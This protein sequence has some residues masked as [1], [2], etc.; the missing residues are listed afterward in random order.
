MLGYNLSGQL[1]NANTST[2]MVPMQVRDNTGGPG[3]T[4][5]TEITAS[6]AHSCGIRGDGSAW[7]W[8]SANLGRRGD[9][10]TTT[11]VNV[12]SRVGTI[13]TNTLWSDWA[14]I[15]SYGSHTCGV[16]ADGTG[17]CWGYGQFGKLGTGSEIDS[18]TPVRVGTLATSTL[19]SDWRTIEGGYGHT[20][21]VRTDGSAWCW[22][23]GNGGVLGGSS[24]TTSVPVRI[25]TDT[26]GVG[27]SDWTHLTVQRA[28]GCGTR[29]D[30]S[31]WCWG[32]N[33][34]G[35]LGDNSTTSRP[36]PVR[37]A[38]D[39]GNAAGWHDWTA[40]A[41]GGDASTCGIRAD[42]TIWCWGSG[43]YGHR[44]DGSTTAIQS[45]PVAPTVPTF[46]C[47]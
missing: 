6:N 32:L 40:I 41:S 21:G 27:W 10:D 42:G 19:W 39:A 37:V 38:T 33:S 18:S 29:S 9:G 28:H 24:T 30:G 25:Q 2:G 20:C 15:S 12:P 34:S 23:D 22:G 43:I 17:W 26:G 5:W 11:D 7:C 3:W 16:R 47:P 1:G 13:G 4:D 46:I 31:A 35:E 36:R 14:K 8:G 45:V 44:G